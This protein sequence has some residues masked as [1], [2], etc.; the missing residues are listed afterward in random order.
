MFLSASRA[1]R[2]IGHNRYST[3]GGDEMRNV[4]PF[5]AEFAGGG[6]A[7]AHNGNLTNAQSLRRELQRDGAIFHST[8][9]TE[10]ILHLIAMGKA[11]GFEERLTDALLR[12]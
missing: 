8:S 3:T 10:V 7:V 11:N 2:A 9:D 12:T 4:Q 6:F 1:S 5:F